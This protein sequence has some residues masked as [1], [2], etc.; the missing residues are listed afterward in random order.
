VV[1]EV[2]ETD[3]VVAVI[4]SRDGFPDLGM[5]RRFVAALPK[6]TLVRSGGARGPDSTA[7][8][9][10]KRSGLLFDLVRPDREKVARMGIKGAL[11]DRNWDVVGGAHVVVAF[12]AEGKSNGTDDALAKARQLGIP[13]L[14]VRAAA[15][16]FELW[17]QPNPGDALWQR[18]PAPESWVHEETC[19]R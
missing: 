16:D 15:G 6:G 4:G 8:F 11:L 18:L 17:K 19:D 5:V 2:A 14:E 1:A 3:L 12:R 9:Q 10:A 13:T 7:E